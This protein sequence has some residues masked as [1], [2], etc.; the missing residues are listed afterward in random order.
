[1]FRFLGLVLDDDDR[2]IGRLASVPVAAI[3]LCVTH[4]AVGIASGPVAAIVFCITQFAVSILPQARFFTKREL[5]ARSN[6]SLRSF[7]ELWQHAVWSRLDR[8]GAV[9]AQQTALPT[10]AVRF[11]VSIF[12]FIGRVF[13]LPVSYSNRN[14]VKAAGKSNMAK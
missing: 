5:V 10:A 1:M 12:R 7:A 4:F 14:I 3:V 13:I 6:G 9:N 2:L 11:R 8:L